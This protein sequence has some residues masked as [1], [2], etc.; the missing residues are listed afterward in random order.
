MNLFDRLKL[1]I[2]FLED[3]EL[4]YKMNEPN[5]A[6]V[7][8]SAEIQGFEEKE[9]LPFVPIR[10][11]PS[12][13]IFQ[14]SLNF[15]KIEKQAPKV[16]ELAEPQEKTLA[17]SPSIDP[18]LDVRSAI[19]T[20]GKD[21]KILDTLPDDREAKKLAKLYENKSNYPECM[22]FYEKTQKKG[23]LLLQALSFAINRSFFS[24][25]LLSIEEIE[26]KE[27]L[28]EILK[29]KKIR[30]IIC[31]QQTLWHH[32]K[33]LSHY[34]ETPGNIFKRLATKDLFVLSNLEYYLKD[35]S[36]K[37]SLWNNLNA[38]FKKT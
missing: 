30:L 4:I 12:V 31:S 23:L 37:R 27:N 3:D 8:S 19:K 6:M 9:K 34:L 5:Q 16:V 32:P 1:A 18:F 14:K 10:K 25:S 26:E 7:I 21:Y 24:C 13:S 35:P 22:I 36:L 28:D 38:Y 15:S 2:T 17:P 29:D 33:L 11:P 20:I